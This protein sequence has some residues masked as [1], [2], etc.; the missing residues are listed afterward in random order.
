M[1]ADF[2]VE[3]IL[4]RAEAEVETPDHDRQFIKPV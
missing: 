3:E 1:N 4:R 2:Q